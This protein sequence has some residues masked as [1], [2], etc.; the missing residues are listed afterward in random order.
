MKKECLLLLFVIAFHTVFPQNLSS[1]AGKVIDA[2]T[3]EV[4]PGANVYLANTAIGIS[5]NE[6]GS[7]N[8][9][10]IPAGKYD[11]T[12]SVLGYKSFSKPM[13]FSGSDVADYL[14]TLEPLP[15][16]LD[17]VY[18]TTSQEKQS[19]YYYGL[20]RK[21]F[22]GTTM[23]SSKCKILNPSDIVVYKEK[24]KIIALAR[25]P[26]QITNKALGYLIHYELKEFVM[27]IS[28]REVL[29]SGVPRFEELSPE[30]P[31]QKEK[32]IKERDR[33]YFGSIPHF[34]ISL[35]KNNL[36]SNYFDLR[37]RD[38]RP[39]LKESIMKDSLIQ[40]KGSV[41][42]TYKREFPEN[43]YPRFRTGVQASEITF[44]GKPVIVYDNGYF[45]DYHD[46]TFRDYMGWTSNIAELL[47]LGYLPSK[48]AKKK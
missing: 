2:K 35:K 4:L 20:F 45:E 46:L 3:K 24:E 28:N 16:Q 33:A 13:L 19:P 1:I 10:K 29:M 7:F 11:F 36:E 15:I 8:L 31:K 25:K 17:P 22:L 41:F 30:S 26:I 32:W 42:L 37:G 14:V 43:N 39:I 48:V 44:T 6:N 18:V 40:F 27:D 23:N 34:L 12:V 21:A 5:A 38:G 9:T 47:P